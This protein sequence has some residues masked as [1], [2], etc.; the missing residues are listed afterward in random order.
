MNALISHL[1]ASGAK[2]ISGSVLKSNTAMRKF[3]KQLDFTETD[4]PDDPS[5]LL[6]TKQLTD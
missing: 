1:K 4:I 3:V 2:R 6:V 5:I